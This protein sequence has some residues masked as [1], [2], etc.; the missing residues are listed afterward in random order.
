MF[1]GNKGKRIAT[2]VAVVLGLAVGLAGLWAGASQA[3]VANLEVIW[4]YAPH[5]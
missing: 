4:L 2:R 5:H 3:H 1:P